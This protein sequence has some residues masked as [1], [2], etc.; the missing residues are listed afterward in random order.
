MPPNGVFDVDFSLAMHNRTGKYFIGRD[1][2]DVARD[3][4]GDIHYY[5][6]V[7]EDA[8]HGLIA[9]VICRIQGYH[10]RLNARAGASGHALRPADRRPILHLEPYTVLT[11]RLRR[12]D[13][14]VIH[15]A[16]PITHPELFERRL[17]PAYAR[18]FD[19]LAAI[20]PHLIFVSIAS[21]RE[22]ERLYPQCRPASSRV[23]YPA[24][25][26][27]IA[28]HT[29]RP[30]ANVGARFLLT[31]GSLGDRK[32][33]ARAIAAFGESDLAEQGVQYVLCGAREPGAEKVAEIAA[34]TPGVLLLSYVSDEELNWL[35]GM[36]SGFVLP[37]LLEG[38]GIPLAEAVQHGAVPLVTADS[39]LEEVAGEGAVTCDALS[40]AS[41]AAG[42]VR[43]IDMTD[44]E[45]QAR[46]VLLRTAIMRFT[47]E[48][49]RTDWRQALTDMGAGQPSA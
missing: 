26:T 20:G 9:K 36:A 39:V 6:F 35:Y 17:N 29:P 7:R 13:A 40:T 3:L 42:M 14:V 34:R 47:M 2:L 43:L 31:T 18:I 22:F 24:M 10:T 16:G 27:D 41:I 23:L 49:F 25:R 46:L 45:R 15:D 48:K 12:E 19:E 4:L 38:F 37:S 21:Q 28:R 33:Q 5:R 44:R 1:L 32:N 11:R 30:V 8:P